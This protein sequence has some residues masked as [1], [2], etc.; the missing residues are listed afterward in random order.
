MRIFERSIAFHYRNLPG[1]ELVQFYHS[2]RQRPAA[3]F[4]ASAG[5]ISLIPEQ[6]TARA[7]SAHVRKDAKGASAAVDSALLAFL[8]GPL[9][10]PY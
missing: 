2:R 5:E 6:V 7:H 8:R 1:R 4:G 10:A 9:V 3:R